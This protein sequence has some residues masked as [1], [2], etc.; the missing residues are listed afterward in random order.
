VELAEAIILLGAVS[1]STYSMVDG[2]LR[3]QRNLSATDTNCMGIY[4]GL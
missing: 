3:N 4:N 1:R 2:G